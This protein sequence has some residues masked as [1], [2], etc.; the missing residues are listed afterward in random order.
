MWTIRLQMQYQGHP[1]CRISLRPELAWGPAWTRYDYRFWLIWH[2]KA[3]HTAISQFVVARATLLNSMK[4]YSKEWTTAQQLLITNFEIINFRRACS[5]H[6]ILLLRRCLKKN[7]IPLSD[8]I[9]NPYAE[10]RVSSCVIL[11]YCSNL[12]IRKISLQINMI[13]LFLFNMD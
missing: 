3:F 6:R 4:R 13:S 9:R 10:I 5:L 7:N 1:I 11:K 8:E 2:G 12:T